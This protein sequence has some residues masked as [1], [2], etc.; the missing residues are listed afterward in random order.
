MAAFE[1][2]GVQ[3]GHIICGAWVVTVLVVVILHPI[4]LMYI[5]PN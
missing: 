3:G 5:C 4:E 1:H 2:G